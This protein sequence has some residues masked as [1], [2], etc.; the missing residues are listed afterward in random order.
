[1]QGSNG[2][3]YALARGEVYFDRFAPGTTDITGEMYFGN[4]PEVNTTTESEELEHFDSDHGVNEK[5]D[6]VTLSQDMTGSMTTD[7]I[8]ADNLALLFRGTKATVSQTSATGLTSTFGNVKQGRYYQLGTSD[9]VPYG[10]RHVTNVV[11]SISASP[12]TMLGNYDVD[13][14]LGRIY[15]EPGAPGI[16]EGANIS[17]A[18]D[19]AAYSMDVIVSGAEE[20]EGA[21]R[22]IGYNPKGELLDYFWPRV[23][24]SPNGDFALKSGEDWQ[25]I[26]FN[27][28]FLRKGNLQKV[29]VT[30]R[31]VVA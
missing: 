9:S 25:T 15:I 13:L 5:D 17:V 31:G 8:V 28:E 29:Y 14:D 24:L 30:N 23:K 2:R 3:N 20:I 22:Y 1:M 19:R 11:V 6:A 12:V 21:L 18:F 7:N 4:T 10:F 27:I 16:A 26:P